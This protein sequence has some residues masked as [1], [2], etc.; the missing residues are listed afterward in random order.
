MLNWEKCDTRKLIVLIENFVAIVYYKKY[1]IFKK[2]H[3]FLN[4]SLVG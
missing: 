4:V 3:Y 2:F 1:E